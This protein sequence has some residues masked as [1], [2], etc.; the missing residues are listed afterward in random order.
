ME[1]MQLLNA[2][3]A[4]KMLEGLDIK[5]I[6]SLDFS[7]VETINFAGMRALLFARQQGYKINIINAN[8]Q[9]AT[10]FENAGVT[11]YISIC[12]AP[13]KIDLTHFIQSGEGF[14]SITYNSEDGDSMLKLIKENFPDSLSEKEKMIATAA[15]QV[16]VP[17][18]L[19]GPIVTTGKQRGI[20]FERIVNKKSF[21]RA[22]ADEPENYADYA[23]RFAKMCRQLHTTECNTAVFP[24]VADFYED[25]ISRATLFND[26]E[27]KKMRDFL[28]SVPAATTCLHGDM[29]IGNVITTG[30]EDLWID[31]SEFSYGN[32]N[33]DMAMFYIA[34]T[35]DSEEFTMEY[36]HV[37]NEMMLKFWKIFACEYYGI[38][39]SELETVSER[40][41]PYAA[42]RMVYFT[43]L[44]S[45]QPRNLAF[46]REFLNS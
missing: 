10:M 26:A 7:N 18:P 15:L 3:G 34:C 45:I 42:L 32:P 30:K 28:H 40:L 6:N 20:I 13:V 39:E 38:K 21:S 1:K 25:A 11:H 36:Y 33:F 22:I 24:N 43:T 5:E 8:E 14:S 31:M 46:I 19:P 2:D 16:G 41:K 44:G 17:T 9:V 23:I 37:N 35:Q 27:K 12:R 4:R 29:H